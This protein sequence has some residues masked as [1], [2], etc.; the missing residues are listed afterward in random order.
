[1]LHPEHPHIV[2]INAFWA[3]RWSCDP[4]VLRTPGVNVIPLEIEGYP[5]LFQIVRRGATTIVSV[6][7]D[8]L[9][10]A[11]QRP[12]PLALTARQLA[13]ELELQVS[14]RAFDAGYRFYVNPNTFTPAESSARRLTDVDRAAARRMLA[15]CDATEVTD[16]EMDAALPLLFGVWDRDRLSALAGFQAEFDQLADVRVIVHPAHR[17]RGL[18]RQAVSALAAWG[19][20]R[21]LLVQYEC[22]AWNVASLA[23][24]LALGCWLYAEVEVIL[25]TP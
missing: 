7:P 5:G 1:M 4:V 6:P 23:L 21:D 19:L 11:R 17:R 25:S 12:L 10:A 14:D 15:E 8:R 20:E 16:A 22:A 13:A 18:A 24:A 3:R 9:E 2:D